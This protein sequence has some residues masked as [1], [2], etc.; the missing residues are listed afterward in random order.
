MPGKGIVHL[1]SSI[2]DPRNATPFLFPK[3]PLAPRMMRAMQVGYP[4]VTLGLVV[5]Y[6]AYLF[7]ALN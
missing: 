6:V 7:A 1:E 5:A 2:M 4:A 3:T